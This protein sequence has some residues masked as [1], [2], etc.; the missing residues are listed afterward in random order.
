MPIVKPRL[1]RPDDLT[2]RKPPLVPFSKGPDLRRVASFSASSDGLAR[3]QQKLS[4]GSAI[5]NL[6]SDVRLGQKSLT[7]KDI[8]NSS[9]T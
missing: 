2:P 1:P 7:E 3:K 9:V 8:Q 4:N 5:S 6:G